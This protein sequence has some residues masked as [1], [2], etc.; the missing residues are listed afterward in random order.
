MFVTKFVSIF[1]ALGCFLSLI[2]SV[3]ASSSEKLLEASVN[4]RTEYND[5]IFL[6]TTPHD[7]VSRAVIT[8][9]LSGVIKEQNWQVKLNSKLRI[10]QYS[11]HTLDSNGQF[12]NLTGQ[13]RAERDIFSI[14]IG[15]DLTS[16]LRAS[17]ADFG[18][19]SQQVERKTQSVTPRYTRL[20]TERLNLALSYSYSDADYIDNEDARFVASYIDTGSASLSYN[21]TEKDQ[22][23]INL[24]AVDYTRKDRL[25]DSQ[26][27]DVNLGF[28]H[29]FSKTLSV[30]LAVG[31]SKRNSTNLQ[32][33]VLDFF[34]GVIIIPQE[35]NTKSRGS[36]LVL[37]MKQS[38]ETGSIAA[39]ASRNTTTNSF[40]GIDE[41]EK[42]VLNYDDRLSSLW[43]YTIVTSYEDTT[44]ISAVTT[45]TN[46]E[47]LFL[48]AKTYYSLPQNWNM[49]LS[50]RYVQ[51][52]FKSGSS[53]G[54]TP[55]SNRL[56]IG[57]TYN[58]PPLST[59]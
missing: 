43:R 22:L 33:T 32:T 12:F 46:R 44:S 24:Q 7:S 39:R 35:I 3:T 2:Y 10:N 25:G 59:F 40:G 16:S 6:T 51:R 18:I 41:I 21:L 13:Y 14:S 5:N 34:G 49:S 50:Y 11:D 58:L 20:L 55:E 38:L 4:V 15:H 29:K 53:V 54:N 9:S 56:Q 57:L 23:S 27:F 47:V 45:S 37:G 1:S 8:P 19:S 30:D 42:L 17:S 26:L 48:E 31:A 52:K 28:D 36:T